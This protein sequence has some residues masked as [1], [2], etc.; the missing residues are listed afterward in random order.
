MDLV[1]VAIGILDTVVRVQHAIPPL[2]SV[3]SVALHS[4]KKKA[5]K[6]T[7]KKQM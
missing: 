2:V 6:K 4:S 3:A 7:N 1:G 5:N